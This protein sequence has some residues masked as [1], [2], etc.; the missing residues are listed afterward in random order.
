MT[1]YSKQKLIDV[2]ID[3]L[4]EERSKILYLQDAF[5]IS[6]DFWDATYIQEQRMKFEAIARQ[7]VP[8]PIRN[9]PT[10]QQQQC[11]WEEMMLMKLEEVKP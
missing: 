7:G 11:R 1:D 8:D 6:E 3:M 5:G 10:P 4:V 2:L 9:H